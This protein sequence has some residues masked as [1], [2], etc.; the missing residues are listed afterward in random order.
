[1]A[2]TEHYGISQDLWRGP[3][4]S[5]I[6]PFVKTAALLSLDINNVSVTAASATNTVLLDLVRVRPVLVF[7]DP[8]F[9]VIG[10]LLEVRDTGELAGRSVGRAMLNGGV[11]V[12]KVT[13]VM[14]IARREE[15]T[16]GERVNRS[17]TPLVLQ[18]A[19]IP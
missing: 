6:H 19:Q 5:H 2:S 15:S 18:S 16:G 9:F 3:A 13:E 10:S 17:I 8:F 1:M 14:N 7:L 11:P 12:A 4:T